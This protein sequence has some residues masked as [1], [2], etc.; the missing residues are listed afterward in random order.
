MNVKKM[1]EKL[2]E[3]QAERTGGLSKDTFLVYGALK[4]IL[5]AGEEKSSRFV[6]PTIEEVTKYCHSRG[7]AVDAARWFNH[8][9]AN[10]WMVGRTKM[11]D[12]RAAV[13]KW[14][15]GPSQALS[16]PAPWDNP[17]GRL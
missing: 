2:E 14:E 3:L 13:R 9:Q 1:I 7:G 10:G 11:K 12:W 5:L 8:Y 16:A 15:N 17:E 4:E 6:L